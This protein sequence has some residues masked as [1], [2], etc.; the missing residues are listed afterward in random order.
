MREAFDGPCAAANTRRSSSRSFRASRSF[1]SP[2][3]MYALMA[4][5]LAAPGDMALSSC[6]LTVVTWSTLYPS[7]H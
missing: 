1:A 3:A 2:A 5:A 4:S 6:R 7:N